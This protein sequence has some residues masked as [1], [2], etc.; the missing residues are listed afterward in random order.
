MINIFNNE[1]QSN[2]DRYAEK[3]KDQFIDLFPDLLESNEDW[4]NIYVEPNLNNQSIQRADIL[5]IGNVSSTFSGGSEPFKRQFSE[6]EAPEFAREI[7][8]KNFIIVIELKTHD[9]KDI[10]VENN[11][12]SVPYTDNKTG[13]IHWK[14]ATQQNTAQ[15]YAIKNAI[16]SHS[17]VPSWSLRHLYFNNIKD[18]DLEKNLDGTRLIG[19]II[20]SDQSLDVTL[21]NCAKDLFLKQKFTRIQGTQTYFARSFNDNH[22][23]YFKN[24]EFLSSKEITPLDQVKMLEISQERADINR[25]FEECGT[26]MLLFSGHGGTGKTIRLLQLANKLKNDDSAVVLFLTYNVALR[27]NLTRLAKLMRMNL[28]QSS[29]GIESGIVF[30]GV[31][32]FCQRVILRAS[33]Y[34][35]LGIVNDLEEF[36]K[37]RTGAKYKEALESFGNYLSSGALN[38]EDIRSIFY[39]SEN[40]GIS[41]DYVL[42]DE[43]QDWNPIERNIVV[44]FF[45]IKNIICAYGIAQET[46]GKSLSWTKGLSPEKDFR[47]IILRKSV[48]MKR[49]LAQFIKEFSNEVFYENSYKDLD[50]L[51]SGTGGKI[52][53]IEGDYTKELLKEFILDKDEKFSPVDLLVCI[54]NSLSSKRESYGGKIL[55]SFGKN[56]NS[57]GMNVWDATD[58]NIRES[59]PSIDDLRIV[60]YESCRG[61]EGWRVLNMNFDEFWD[62]KIS[63]YIR[64]REIDE[65]QEKGGIQE[66]LFEPLGETF[67]TIEDEAVNEAAK[68]ALI[69]LT[70]GVS[71]ITIHI[72]NRD[73]WMGKTLWKLSQRKSLEDFVIWIGSNKEG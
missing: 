51:E 47:R 71:E 29:N 44:L 55:S 28:S 69:A 38:E 32:Q 53:I 12:I 41:H 59:M 17:N 73:S 35:D 58:I 16:K 15:T 40:E 20:T 42:I 30:A 43:C 54:P 23:S 9:R 49:N 70:R 33:K 25:W 21:R 8:L 11:E 66:E 67:T 7:I 1:H 31:L 22:A 52:T 19:G 5:V 36:R 48:R 6:S 56:L 2:E 3:L 72:K 10:K 39:K 60:N 37:D 4:V 63:D 13:E 68:W 57:W 45:G 14:N 62:H 50:I 64:Q 24:A 65:R 61:L 27:S 34:F 46:R 18:D 26:K